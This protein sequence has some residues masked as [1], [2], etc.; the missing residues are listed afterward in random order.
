MSG[1][2]HD[3]VNVSDENKYNI[4]IIVFIV[5]ETRTY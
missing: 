5:V 1:T 4:L 2:E 3:K